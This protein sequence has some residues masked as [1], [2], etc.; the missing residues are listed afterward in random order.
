MHVRTHIRPRP[1][2]ITRLRLPKS[3]ITEQRHVRH[4]VLVHHVLA[5]RSSATASSGSS[6]SATLC[7]FRLALHGKRAQLDAVLVECVSN[8]QPN[9][10]ASLDSPAHTLAHSLTYSLI[11]FLLLRHSRAP[12]NTLHDTTRRPPAMPCVPYWT[13]PWC[14]RGHGSG[15]LCTNR[16]IP[17]IMSD[18]CDQ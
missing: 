8:S 17:F 15:F 7:A 18:C 4:G 14:R 16:K 1:S 2:W 6:G 11:L 9:I 13:A 10:H 12:K 5:R 3:D